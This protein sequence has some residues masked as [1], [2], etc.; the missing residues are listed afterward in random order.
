MRSYRVLAVSTIGIIHLVAFRVP[1]QCIDRPLPTSTSTR[2]L[3][4][5]DAN[6][7]G[8]DDDVIFYGPAQ[9]GVARGTSLAAERYFDRLASGTMATTARLAS[10]GIGIGAQLMEGR[11]LEQCVGSSLPSGIIPARDITRNLAV[12]GL[13]TT[14]KKVRFGLAAKYASEQADANRLSMLLVDAGLARDF[15]LGA[16]VP[17]TVAVAM[18]SI[19]PDPTSATELGIPRRGSIGLSSGGPVG[20]V[21]LTVMAQ[22]GFERTG[23]LGSFRNK[24][25]ARGGMEVGY[26]WLDGYSVA[27]RAGARTNDA[28]TPLRHATFGAG[29]VLD[30]LSFDYAGEVLVGS[31]LAHRFGVRLR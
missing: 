18:Q 25:M 4:M 10:V 27:V 14:F 24:P 2:A 30:R 15:T 26:T 7:A 31:R 12:V 11:N 16:F 29:L 23:T 20:P 13:A 22:S 5:G 6:V 1:A 19:G 3:G 21:D 28:M 8:R 17:L 9:L